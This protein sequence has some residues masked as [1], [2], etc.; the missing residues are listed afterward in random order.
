MRKIILVLSVGILF[1]LT[2]FSIIG[3]ILANGTF[4]DSPSDYIQP[5]DEAADRARYDC[6]ATRRR[7]C[8][9]TKNDCMAVYTSEREYDPQ[10]ARID[11]KKIERMCGTPY[12]VFY[13]N[14]KD[15]FDLPVS[16]NCPRSIRDVTQKDV[17]QLYACRDL[18]TDICTAVCGERYT[19]TDVRKFW[20]LNGQFGLACI[21]GSTEEYKYGGSYQEDRSRHGCFAALEGREDM[22]SQVPGGLPEIHGAAGGRRMWCVKYNYTVNGTVELGAHVA[23]VGKLIKDDSPLCPNGICPVGK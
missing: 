11:A 22:A 17:A 1:G 6:P 13:N 10:C 19:E 3:M 12:P 5:Q 21:D 4:A 14:S 16:M 15:C 20:Q 8:K 23:C 9:N 18:Y 7:I 2:F